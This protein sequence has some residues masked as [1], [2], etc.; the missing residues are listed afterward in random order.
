MKEFYVSYTRRVTIEGNITIKAKNEDD[1]TKRAE[2]MVANGKFGYAV[3]K[4]QGQVLAK[5][6][7]EGE[8]TDENEEITIDEANEVDE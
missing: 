7:T 3:V 8:V 6:I 4:I 2:K 1:A 5:E